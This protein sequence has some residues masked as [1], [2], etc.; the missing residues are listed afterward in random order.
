MRIVEIQLSEEFQDENFYLDTELTAT[1]IK[2]VIAPIM[3]SQPSKIFTSDELIGELRNAYK[4]YHIEEVNEPWVEK[5]S[6]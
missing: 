5:V 6:F 4:N 3:S 1:E 2:N